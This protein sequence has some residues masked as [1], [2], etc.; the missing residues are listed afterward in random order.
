MRKLFTLLALAASIVSAS[1]KDFTDLLKVSINNTTG[2]AQ[3][4]TISLDQQADGKFVFALK[5]FVLD[6]GGQQI[7]V[8]TIRIDQVAGID[9]NGVTTLVAE[10]TIRIVEGDIVSPS[11]VWIGPTMLGDV[12]VKLIGEQR[13]DQLYAVINI[14]MQATMQQ[15]IQVTFGNG[16]YQIA[17][18]DFEAFHKEGKIDEP[19]HWHSFASCKGSMAGFVKGTPHTFVSDVTR[20]ESSGKSSVLLTS[21]SIFGII[22]N[23][24][25]TTGRMN[26]GAMSASDPA[27]HAETDLSS[28]DT[29]QN[30]DPFYSI[31]NGR[32]DSIAVW[33]KF[34]QS[35]P[36]ATY[37]YA[38]MSATVTDG[39]Y[40]QDPE[41]KAYTNIV[42]KAKHPGIESK[43]YTW[44]RISLPFSYENNSLPPRAI[45]VTLSTNAT[46]G[47]GSVD[48]LYVDDLN[49]VYNQD[50]SVSKMAVNGQTLELQDSMSMTNQGTTPISLDNITVETKAPKVIKFMEKTDKG[51]LAYIT[52]ASEDLLTFKTYKLNIEGATSGIAGLKGNANSGTTVFDLQGRRV[53]KMNRRGVYIIRN[54]GTTTKVIRR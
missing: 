3:Q 52:V 2:A 34:K 29:D 35:K 26:A 14:D 48:T 41:D 38:T 40:Y 51:A 24:T 5:N 16:G 42:A 53:D 23:G 46:P 9:Q 8:G 1:A 12:P 18:S 21:T 25:L 22:A 30:G 43:D 47:K 32:P 50:I 13:G 7:G 44:Q 20:P 36:N 49:L 10:K 19:N 33:V 27:N 28:T 17:N 31:M 6:M 39:S 15:S 54:N 45:L 11:G 37:P 4:A